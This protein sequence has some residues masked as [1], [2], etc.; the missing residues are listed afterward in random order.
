[1]K[2]KYGIYFINW[3]AQVVYLV[4]TENQVIFDQEMF[5]LV[6]QNILVQLISYHFLMRKLTII[7][8][9]MIIKFAIWVIYSETIAPEELT[10]F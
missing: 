3:L 6:N 8:V 5:L 1:M 10:D 7:N 2:Y 9:L 4:K